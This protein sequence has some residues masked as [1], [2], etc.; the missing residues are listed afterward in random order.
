MLP[1][2]VLFRKGV[3]VDRV[4]GFRDLGAKDDFTTKTLERLLLKKGIIDEKK[5]DDE[6]RDVEGVNSRGRSVRSSINYDSDSD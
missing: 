3:A 4:V 1:C 2:V 5:V 6:Y